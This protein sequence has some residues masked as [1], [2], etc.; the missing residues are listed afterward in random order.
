M[1]LALSIPLDERIAEHIATTEGE[2]GLYAEIIA[3]DCRL[4][5]AVE[6]LMKEHDK[7]RR[8]LSRRLTPKQAD[9]LR[10]AL[11]LHCRRG[12][13]LVYEAFVVD[14]GGES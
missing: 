8:A 1:G 5:F 12:N 13:D 10:D 11:D 14:T 4:R 6:R 9:A 7:F 3:A 2:H